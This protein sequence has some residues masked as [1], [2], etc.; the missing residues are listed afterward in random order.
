MGHIS[1]PKD[2]THFYGATKYFVTAL[3][4]GIRHELYDQK[5]HIRVT[6][7]SPGLVETEFVYRMFE[8][9]SLS[10]SQVYSTI[11]VLEAKDIS[12]AVVFALGAPPHMSVGEIIVRPVEQRI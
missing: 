5:S 1:H 12:S 11:K 6:S 2:I 8:K 10:A 9:T 7:I 3:T 4:E